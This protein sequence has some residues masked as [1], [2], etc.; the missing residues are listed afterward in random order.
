MIEM[1]SSDSLAQVA[2]RLAQAFPVLKGEKDPVGSFWYFYEEL[3]RNRE[4]LEW[5]V[6]ADKKR[7]KYRDEY[8][9]ALDKDLK[10]AISQGLSLRLVR[11][12]HLYYMYHDMPKLPSQ[13]TDEELMEIPGVTPQWVEKYRK[14]TPREE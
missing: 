14:Y 3:Y 6:E 5:R 7:Q 4:R 10:K 1:P 9:V 2:G 8:E 11:K 12:F 13:M